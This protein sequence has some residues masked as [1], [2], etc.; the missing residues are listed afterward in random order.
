M[1]KSTIHYHTGYD[2][3]TPAVGECKE[4]LCLA[5]GSKMKKKVCSYGPTGRAEA[6][7]KGKHFHDTFVCKNSGKKWHT[8]VVHLLEFIRKCPS[9]VLSDLIHNEIEDIKKTK[10]PTKT[11]YSIW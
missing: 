4:M 2:Y 9:K 11:D 7:S 8:Q 1:S 6:M 10:T 5:C 3:F